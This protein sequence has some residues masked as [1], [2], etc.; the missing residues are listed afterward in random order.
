LIGFGF[1]AAGDAFTVSGAIGQ[2]DAGRMSGGPF[3]LVVGFCGIIA[4]VQTP[5]SPL[6]SILSTGTNAVVLS[7]PP[8]SAGPSLQH[9]S[10]LTTTN[11]IMLRVT[12]ADDGTN[13]TVLITPAA[14]NRFF[15]LKWP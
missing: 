13:K 14:G 5:G 7:W 15:R 3:S 12:S 6:L 11:W 9:K 10:D 1:H 2:P 4:A 8:P